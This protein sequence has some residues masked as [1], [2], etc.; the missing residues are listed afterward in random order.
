MDKYVCVPTQEISKAVQEE[1]FRKG[2]YWHSTD[3]VTPSIRRDIINGGGGVCGVEGKGKQTAIGIYKSGKLEWCDIEYYEKLHNAEFYPIYKVFTEL[4][5]ISKPEK[6][7][8]I[9]G[10]KYSEETIKRA[11]QEYVK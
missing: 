7:C 3:K 1:L 5:D 9:D 10:K 11:L 2:C 6:M 8:T 4:P